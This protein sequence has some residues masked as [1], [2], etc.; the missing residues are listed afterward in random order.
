M[1]K[2]VGKPK[3]NSLLQFVYEAVFLAP[4]WAYVVVNI[5]L[6]IV[7]AILTAQPD[8]SGL[9]VFGVVQLL[10]G[11]NIV[12]AAFLVW[13]RLNRSLYIMATKRIASLVA[14]VFIVLVPIAA[15]VTYNDIVNYEMQQ[16]SSYL[17][18]VDDNSDGI[19]TTVPAAWLKTPQQI[20]QEATSQSVW[21][22]VS[23]IAEVG[24]F[25]VPLVLMK[26]I[27]SRR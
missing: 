21:F 19:D 27:Y 14:V 18:Q 6:L 26:F 2:R 13:R 15:F 9:A 22:I 25:V 11:I 3:Q 7:A 10:I 8:V 16:R 4:V 5:I 12:I 23:S 1:V 24:V 17:Q 20:Q